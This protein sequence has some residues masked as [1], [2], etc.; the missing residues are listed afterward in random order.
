MKYLTVV[1]YDTF[2]RFFSAI[3]DEVRLR[4][5]EAEFL[6]LALFPS[7]Y[8]YLA[9]ERKAVRLLPW[10][11][12]KASSE[13]EAVEEA[14]LDRIGAYHSYILSGAGGRPDLRVRE[15][16]AK[17]VNAVSEILRE[18][19][20]DRVIM[21]GDTRIACE[22]LSFC[23]ARDWPDVPKFHFE[24]GPG[25]T[26]I[27]DRKGVNAN[28]SFRHDVAALTGE[29][30]SA[31]APQKRSRFKRNPVFRA[32]DH[33]LSRAL[34]AVARLPVE[35]ETLPMPRYPERRYAACLQ[36]E[37]IAGT[38]SA[39]HVLV[40]LQVPDDAN[41]IHHNPLG[42]GDAQFV[43]LATRAVRQSGGH[44]LVREHP[45]Y[46]RKYSAEMYRFISETP[47]VALSSAELKDDLSGASLVITVNSMTGFD[48]YMS[49]VPS[50]L[51]GRAFY[52]HLPGIVRV[53][54][55]EELIGAIDSV[56][57][58]SV[59]ELVNGCD[60][61]AIFAEAKM[62]YLIEGHWLDADLV[63]P[64]VIAERVV[65]PEGLLCDTARAP[66]GL[67]ATE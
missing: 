6:H 34:K 46:R 19:R 17:Y 15:R 25:G 64:A 47:G 66:A 31:E 54:R 2:A 32:M 58:R 56:K 67:V 63:A 30:Y 40:A 20:P 61:K 57:G 8:L 12:T 50:I 43:E 59:R 11:A 53:D 37:A 60:P 22:A 10:E 23:L 48:A 45:L 26:T 42:L 55:E 1:Y 35:W 18:F 51:L 36:Q 52:D 62:R 44:V 49:D 7:A 14:E 13:V 9:I 65:E 33:L 21:S 24:Q 39:P 4:D 27:L 29:G 41:N 28:C 38:N 5:G 16:A 3:E